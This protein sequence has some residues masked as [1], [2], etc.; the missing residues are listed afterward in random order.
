MVAAKNLAGLVFGRLTVLYL[1]TAHKRRSWVCT[2]VCGK[3]KVVA[4]RELVNG[5]TKS[6]GCIARERIVKMSKEGK[7]DHDKLNA[8]QKRSY[9]KWAMMWNRVRN[10]TGKSACYAGVSVCTEWL[11]FHKFYSDM[12]APQHGWSLDRIDY[13]GDYSAKNCRW[14]PLARQAQNTRR[15][16]IE[17]INGVTACLSQHARDY[18]LP[19]DVVFD[20]VNKL[21]WPVE[22]ALTTNKRECNTKGAGGTALVI[23]EDNMDK[24]KSILNGDK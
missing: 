19:P 24:I 12:G 15:N 6:C 10:P 23:N 4:Q 14:V 22:R 17:T 20:R 9:R 18:G 13:T 21:G 2:C 7:V 3:R 1:D 5:D 16:R 8:D 11:D